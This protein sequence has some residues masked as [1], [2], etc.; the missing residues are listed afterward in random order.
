MCSIG[1]RS[2]YFNFVYRVIC[3]P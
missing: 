2:R 3:K 1:S